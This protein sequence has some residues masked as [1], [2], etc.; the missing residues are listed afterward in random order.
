MLLLSFVLAAAPAAAPIDAYAAAAA[1]FQRAQAD[2]FHWTAAD[3]F[4]ERFAGRPGATDDGPLGLPLL[5]G[6]GT[7]AFGRDL[8]GHFSRWQLQP[9][10]ARRTVVDG[11]SLCLRWEQAGRSGAYRVGEAGWDRPLPAGARSVAA[12]FPITSER[13]QSAGIPVEVVIESWSPVVSGDDAAAALPV[14]FF[15]VYARNRSAA[16]AKLDLALFLPNFLGWRK[17]YG[18]VSAANDNDSDAMDEETGRK[19]GPRLWP[20]RSN[21]GNYSEPAPSAPEQGLLTAALHRRRGYEVP[22]QDMEGEVLLGVGGDASVRA[23]RTTEMFVQPDRMSGPRNALY[24]QQGIERS[25]F[26]QGRLPV[27]DRSWAMETNEGE[28]S[29]VSGGL[30]LAPGAEGHFTLMVVWDLPLMEVGSGRT[31]EKEYTARYGTAGHSARQIALDALAHRA[32][33]RE[34]IDRWQAKTLGGGALAQQ[35]RNG[36][37]LN[38]LYY[39]VSGGAMWVAKEHPR[40]GLKPPLLGS[41]EHFSIQ[42]GFDSGYYFCSTFDLWPYAQPAFELNWPHLADVMLRDF[43]RIAPLDIPDERY[44]T[45]QA[46]FVPRKVANKVPHDLGAPSGD[47]WSQVNEYGSTRDSN[48]WKD[49]DP[50]FVLSVYLHH[51]LRNTRPTD[52]EWRILLGVSDF[53]VSQDKRGDGLPFHDTQGDSTWDAL[54][55]TGPSPFSGALTIG[56]WAALA[57]LA[58]TRGDA[59]QAKRCADRLALAQA[60]FEKYFWNGRYYRSAENGK[61]TEWLLTDALFGILMADASG[62]HGLLPTGHLAAHLQ[63]VADRNWKQFGNG[64]IGP[65][66][67]APPTGPIPVGQSQVG[68]V[69]VG[70]ARSAAA[71]MRRCGLEEL[72]GEM[73]DA[74]NTTLYHD[75]GLQFR[76]PA[77]WRPDHTFRA[78]SNMRPLASWFNQLD[79]HD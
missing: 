7:G 33:W 63:A 9:G 54:Q 53:M 70:S 30:D 72:A 19:L 15:D 27:Q 62:L 14:A 46:H 64:R 61:Q 49:H 2:G 28:A 6:I 11:A 76:T 59:A 23:Q 1:R 51:H 25:F 71:L 4:P 57:D 12:L 38:D 37:A 26:S 24:F 45:A 29:A 39:V 34:A 75:S 32:A 43:T 18:M 56:A 50:E 55:F 31:W 47:P 16:P 35:R 67:L 68:E 78:P 20:E 42:E 74:V 66:L 3:T 48:V 52:E 69:L 73:D 79:R 60:S 65:A 21:T 44:V 13:I 10:F 8:A 77:A 22:V 36:A 41:G 5:G 17:G 40:P 58:R